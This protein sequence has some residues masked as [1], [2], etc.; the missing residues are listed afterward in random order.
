M[1]NTLVIGGIALALVFSLVVG[2]SGFGMSKKAC[3]KISG[4]VTAVYEDGAKDAVFK[5]QG[6]KS[7]F[8]ITKGFEKAFSLNSLLEKLKGKEVSIVYTDNWNPLGSIG[9]SRSIS[10]LSVDQELLYFEFQPK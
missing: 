8:Y 4:I 3:K 7:V 10:E 6:Q 2:R 5:L 1:K 9:E